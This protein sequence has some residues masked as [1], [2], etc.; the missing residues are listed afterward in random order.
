MRLILGTGLLFLATYL[1]VD[2]GTKFSGQIGV[3]CLA[4]GMILLLA[5]IRWEI[6]CGCDP[7]EHA[8]YGQTN[9]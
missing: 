1:Y 4:L 5:L 8:E 2:I 9:Q 6:L 3:A 7:H